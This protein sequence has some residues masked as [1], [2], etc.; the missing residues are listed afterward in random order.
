MTGSL[1]PR[2]V[3]LRD[4]Q[5]VAAREI[6]PGE[7]WTLGRGADAALPV[8]E[9]SISRMHARVFCDA[10]GVH[11]EDLGT[12][13]GTFVDG[14]RISGTL[15]LRDGSLIRLG[16]STN[17]DPILLRFEDPGTRLLEAMTAPSPASRGV[18]AS[19][20]EP[21]PPAPA[22][23]GE[24]AGDEALTGPVGTAPPSTPLAA[25]PEMPAVAGSD[26]T[27]GEVAQ[28]SPEVEEPA[29]EATTT[30]R[31]GTVLA[32][33]S[34]R[35]PWHLALWGAGALLLVWGF[36]ALLQS[37]QKPWQ[38]VRVEPLRVQAGDRVSIRG[39]EVEPAQTLKVFV[40]GQS[41][42]IDEMKVGE[43]V[44]TTPESASSEAGVRAVPLRV[45]RKGIVLLRQTLQYETRPEIQA[46]KPTEAAV[47]DEVTL[48][49]RGF[50]SQPS[51]V[52]VLVNLVPAPVLSAST[53][54]VRFRVPVVTHNVTV[55][56]AVE[57]HVG[58]WTGPPAS[59]RVHARDAPC[60]ALTFEPRR[61]SERVWEVRD[62][63]GPA[64]Y[65]EAPPSGGEK[66]PAAVERAVAR[67]GAAFARAASDPGVHFDVHETRPPSLVAV[68]LGPSSTRIARWSRRL[69]E[70]FRDQVPELAQTG[71]V[72]FW[73]A[74]VLNE[75]LDV[76]VKKQPA[77]LLPA[78]DPLRK[79]LDRVQRLN[80]DT[81]GQGCPSEAEIA[82]LSPAERD[83]FEGALLHLPR[84]F[85]EVGG[86]WE[87]T[88]EDVFSE[89]PTQT[90]LELRLELEQTGTAL[91][92]RA[93][94]FEV[95]GPGIRW[96]PAPIEGLTGRVKLSAETRVELT[97]P[98]KPPRYL[99]Q[100]SGVVAQGT[101]TGT[102]RTA[103]RKQ[104]AFQLVLKGAD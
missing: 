60:Y 91:E 54:R 20:P 77:R 56:S 98:P 1:R 40:G 73:N 15:T 12:P 19:P 104:G 68:G 78:D 59:L 55:D 51:R 53:E 9:R 25:P 67:L 83:A 61:V 58:E 6:A 23:G 7:E 39:V 102:Y 85:G 95:R 28:P 27:L 93:F 100:L 22:D 62:P 82:T 75:L 97:L 87:G 8:Q 64:L 70:H 89:E 3:V 11:L 16:Q 37:T 34:G 26:G 36:V 33:L 29:G 65:V 35:P 44:F 43:V 80:L 90:R 21:E 47:G 14:R 92:G 13:N 42:R 52:Q 10:A 81:G 103:Q 72:P 2:L 86:V 24:T 48:E 30:A 46:V 41:A 5:E 31:V 18:P 71:L 50:A 88:F 4:G 94:I 49:G 96:S 66:V 38:S 76:F 57:V 79:A 17:P 99:T 69:D 84:R 101:L 74:V 32:V 63:L 45:E